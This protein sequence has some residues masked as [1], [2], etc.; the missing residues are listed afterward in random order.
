MHGGGYGEDA[1][2]VMFGD[3]SFMRMGEGHGKIFQE[4]PFSAGGGAPGGESSLF[5]SK[6]GVDQWYS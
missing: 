1:A 2:D 4:S 6:H 3:R 5:G